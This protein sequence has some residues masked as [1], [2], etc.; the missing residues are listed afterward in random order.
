PPRPP[1]TASYPPAAPSGAESLPL[2]WR[3]SADRP[4]VL[5][6]WR[7]VFDMAVCWRQF[8]EP[9]DPVWWVDQLS[10]EQFSGTSLPLLSLSLSPADGIWPPCLET[11]PLSLSPRGASVSAS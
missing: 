9:N 4:D 2:P 7:D 1:A 6:R 5:G 11:I 10:P 3:A 8:V